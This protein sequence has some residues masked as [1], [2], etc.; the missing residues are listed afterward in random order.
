MTCLLCGSEHHEE[1]AQVESFGFPLVYY[2]C[3]ECGLIFQSAEDNQAKDPRFYAETYRQ[4]YQSSVEPTSKDLWIQ[5]HRALSLVSILQAVKVDAPQRILDIGAST[6]VLLDAFQRAFGGEVVGVEPGDAY[7]AYAQ[8]RGLLMFADIEELV[9]THPPRFDLV[10]MIHVLEHLPDPVDMLRLIRKDLLQENGILLLEVP[11]FYAH[12]SYEL[13]HLTCFTPNTLQQVL[14]RAGFHVFFFH[15]HGHPRSSLLNLY[16]TALAQP[17]PE[18]A[19]Q[20][21]LQR[22]RMVRFKRRIGLYYRR[23]VQ[24]VFPQRAWLPL[25][26]TEEG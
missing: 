26:G 15:R 21:S 24:R 6:G 4:I 11:N 9:K 7:R 10:S 20:P 16:L 13:A 2:Q 12:D 23:V 3:D 8:K 17:L 18:D 14:R 5:E 25:P 1:F 22:D 19:P